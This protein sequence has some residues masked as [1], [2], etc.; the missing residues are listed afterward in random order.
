VVAVL[1]GK[2]S[3]F[4][5]LRAGLLASFVTAYKLSLR[6]VERTDFPT[7]REQRDRSGAHRLRPAFGRKARM[8]EQPADSRAWDDRYSAD[9]YLYGTEPNDFLVEQ[10]AGISFGTA[11]CL[12]DGEGRNSVFLAGLGFEV[13]AVDISARGSEKT[14]A[15]AAERGVEV[16]VITSDLA[17]FDL[18]SDRWDLIVSIFA[19]LP[20]EVRRDLH[21]RLPRSLR[22][23]GTLILEAYRPEQAERATGGPPEPSRLFDLSSLESEIAGLDFILAREIERDVSE[24]SGHSGAG[25]VVQ[26]VGRRAAAW[27][28]L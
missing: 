17:G 2:K 5:A 12:A 21:T 23:G 7:R 15:L 19:H 13:T 28:M 16:E 25:A 22:P 10:A 4:K 9:E 6:G 20:P 14:R 8:Q 26:L 18:G 27:Q 1:I 3:S 11:L 24:G